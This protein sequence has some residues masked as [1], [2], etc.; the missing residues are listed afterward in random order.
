MSAPERKGSGKLFHSFPLTPDR[1]R[2]KRPQDAALAGRRVVADQDLPAFELRKTLHR[3]II[4]AQIAVHC[5][6]LAAERSLVRDHVGGTCVKEPD[7]A[8]RDDLVLFAELN[9]LL[10]E[11]N[12]E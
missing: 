6:L 4:P 12:W 9:E 10:V 8:V 11:K 3:H 5:Q 2:L 7:P 1:P